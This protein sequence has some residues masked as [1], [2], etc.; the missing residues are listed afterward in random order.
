MTLL[1]SNDYAIA[2]GRVVHELQQ[3]LE[4]AAA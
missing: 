4:L 3:E 2:L 1:V